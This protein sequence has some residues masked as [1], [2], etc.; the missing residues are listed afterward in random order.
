[1]N[2]SYTFEGRSG[3]EKQGFPDIIQHLKSLS[4]ETPIID[5]TSDQKYR[6]QDIDLLW[7]TETIE[8]KVDTYTTGNFFFETQSNKERGTPGCFMYTKA[9]WI[10][11][12]FIKTKTLYKLPMPETRMWFEQNI[13]KFAERS[14]KTSCGGPQGYYTTVGRL[15]PI[16]MLADYVHK[17]ILRGQ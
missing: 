17:E 2:N 15:V 14:T 9:D 16:S 8:I 7:G 5:V 3:I 6:N 12:Y 1:M 13:N 4:S 11:Y 10:Y